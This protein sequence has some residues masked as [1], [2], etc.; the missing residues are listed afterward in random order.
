MGGVTSASLGGLGPAGFASGADPGEP[1]TLIFTTV[2]EMVTIPPAMVMK[3]PGPLI[4]TDEVPSAT[5]TV[6]AFSWSVRPVSSSFFLP[7]FS[8]CVHV[9]SE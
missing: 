1:P 4:V 9:E 5:S 6:S 7:I 2:P 8:C 3:P